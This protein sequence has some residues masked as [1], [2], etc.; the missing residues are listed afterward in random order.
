MEEDYLRGKSCG[1]VDDLFV[2]VQHA[3][4][5]DGETS[6]QLLGDSVYRD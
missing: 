6:G 1:T 2:F 3:M 5:I 4:A